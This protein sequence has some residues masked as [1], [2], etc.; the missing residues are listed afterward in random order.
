MLVT[1]NLILGLWTPSPLKNWRTHF[2]DSIFLQCYDYTMLFYI[3][4]TLIH[5]QKPSFVLCMSA[6]HFSQ[7]RHWQ[8][9][10]ANRC[11]L[12]V[13]VFKWQGAL[14]PLTL[15]QINWASQVCLWERG[16]KNQ[17]KRS[18]WSED[19]SWGRFSSLASRKA[20]QPCGTAGHLIP[21]IL[22]R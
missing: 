3:I 21:P 2:F 17:N 4:F 5:C 10:P 16:E 20:T 1:F 15:S 6:L 14:F 7:G 8:G 12:K 19:G 11:R 18:H 13:L 9:E 22:S